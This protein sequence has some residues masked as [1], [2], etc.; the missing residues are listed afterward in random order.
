MSKTGKRILVG[1]VLAFL[2]L[3]AAG[4]AY[5]M[6]QQAMPPAAP[7]PA[8]TPAPGQ[9]GEAPVV[10]IPLSGP[11]AKAQ[12]EISGLGW[13]G[14]SLI[15]LPQYPERFAGGAEGALFAL[16]RQQIED[17]LNGKL[18]G[19]LEPQPVPFDMA[20]IETQVPGFEGFEA[21]AFD[22]DRMYLTI[23]ASPGSA[24]MGYVVAGTMAP[25]LSAARLDPA[26]LTPNQP[27]AR[28]DNTSDE[29]LL[30]S[31]DQI[32]TFFEA[33]GAAVNPAPHAT[34]FNLELQPGNP[35]PL[36]AL[37]YRLTDTTAPDAQGRFW[38]INYFFPGDEDLDAAND[39]LAAGGEG[40]THA[41]SE[42]VERLVEF[43][44]TPEDVRLSDTAPIWLQ[45]RSDGEA[46]NW[47]GLAV[48]PG[49]GFLLATDKFPATILG[50]VAYP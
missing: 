30:I 8:A 44:I 17:F 24:M 39:P 7:L 31:G 12:A 28:R 36:A 25:D 49:Q 9:P 1:V 42:I 45:L 32:L 22:D 13:Y 19:P 10:E 26:T 21:I 41:S 2:A 47:E 40:P 6:V 37:E 35:L 16:P 38:A 23:E 14:D 27:Q 43:Q 48:L 34:R 5:W 20:G 33:N 29:A 50:F 11:I 46:R 18:A 3:A 15:L 4:M